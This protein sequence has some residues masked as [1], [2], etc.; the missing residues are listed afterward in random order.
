MYSRFG[1]A[2]RSKLEGIPEE[3]RYVGMGMIGGKL[4]ERMRF[5]SRKE[6]SFTTTAATI[7]LLDFGFY[8]RTGKSDER[9]RRQLQTM[10]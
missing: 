8:T 3:D 1:W 4:Q 10:Q 6:Y 7:K 2:R 9:D 5:D